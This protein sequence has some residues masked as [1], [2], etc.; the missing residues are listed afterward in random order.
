MT[1]QEMDH[2]FAAARKAPTETSVEEVTAWVGAAAVATTGVLGVAAKVKLFIAKKSLLMLGSVLGTVGI[3]TV[4]TTMFSSSPKPEST[5]T[6]G[7][8]EPNN[9]EQL[10]E[11]VEENTAEILIQQE[12]TIEPISA[13]EVLPIAPIAP[14]APM[15]PQ[16]PNVLETMYI[17]LDE[18]ESYDLAMHV[19]ND[20]ETIIHLE[21]AQKNN[22]SCLSEPG[23]HQSYHIDLR[24]CDEK[25]RNVK[26]SG[27]VTVEKHALKP[28]KRLEV[29]GAFDIV[30]IQG[31]REEVT[32]ETDDNIH[33]YIHVDQDGDRLIL[34]MSND[35]NFKKTTKLAITVSFKDLVEIRSNGVGDITSENQIKGKNL[36]VQIYGVGDITMDVNYRELEVGYAGV[37]DVTLKGDANKVFIDCSG[38]GDVDTYGLTANELSL[39]HSGVGDAN[40][41]ADESVTIEFSGVGS[42]NYKGNPETKEIRKEGIGSVKAR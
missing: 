24:D 29:N 23:E 27:N 6:V 13:P 19:D 11:E 4:A 28:F 40:I 14:M 26:G 15:F 18:L 10:Q 33:E 32:I 12:D 7:I 3:V 22:P 36:D 1:H 34:D 9:Q 20:I 41:F 42:I 38:V 25:K 17:Q 8:V 5:N 31:D 16:A 21:L 2:L 30:L 39:E 35:V 37:G